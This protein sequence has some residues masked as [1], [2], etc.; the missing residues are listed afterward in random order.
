MS[1]QN[2]AIQNLVQWLRW[3]LRALPGDQHGNVI[4]TFA[5]AT[6]PIMGFVGAAVDYSRANSDK[7]AMQAA[8]DATG[9][10]LSKNVNG[11][12]QAQINSQATN[13]FN[14]LFTR[15]DVSNIQITPT[16]TNSNGTQI[17]ITATGT[18]D[19][20]FM[21]VMGFSNMP[22]S[23]SS[24]VKWGNTRLR[25]ALVLDN[26]G[27]MSQNGKMTALKNA[28]TNSSTGLLTQLKNAATQNG[29]VYVSIIP[30]VKDVNVDSVNYNANWIDWTDWDNAKGNGTC[31]NSTYKTG[32]TCRA[33]NKT[34]TP[35]NHDTWNGC[36]TDRGKPGT[37]S[38]PSTGPSSLNTDTNVT[39]PD[40]TNKDTLF[41]AEQYSSCPDATVK[42]L[43]YDWTG[44][45]TL[46]NSMTPN[47][48]TN[49]AIGLQLGWQSLVGGGP[50]PAPPAMDPNYQ[51]KQ[52]IILLTDGLNT[53]DR[54]YGDGSNH[55][56][57]VDDRQKMT[58]D[59]IHA[60]KITLYTVQVNTSGDPTSTLLQNCAGSWS[61]DL[62][63]DTYPDSS[64]FFLLTSSNAIITTFAQI[65]TELSDLRV[66]K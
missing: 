46:V 15:K 31:S 9:L 27:S 30:F 44:M 24:T 34:W 42:A 26:T 7:A 20:T 12:T 32:Y 38:A 19:T 64:K 37:S 36:I 39:A 60:A 48:S 16:Y 58:C 62:K 43:S 23:V 59:N 66:A 55:A 21:K 54:W 14:A 51:Y 61:T 35:N 33:A 8:I 57:Q 10:M 25:V 41:P 50:F 52:V 1:I 28:L 40:T 49:Q 11:M 4:L 17:V 56:Q 2:P 63:T 5:L 53:Q 3:R 45:T 18:V 22:I 29:D 13:Y 65:A 6:V 47:G